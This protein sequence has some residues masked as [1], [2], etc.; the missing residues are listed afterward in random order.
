MCCPDGTTTRNPDT[1]TGAVIDGPAIPP[2]VDRATWRSARDELLARFARP[3][4]DVVDAGHGEHGEELTRAS[5]AKL[6]VRAAK[7]LGGDGLVVRLLDGDPALFSGFAEEALA[8]RGA[9]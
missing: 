8:L 9:R 7:A 2:V 3:D 6:L 5:R 4:V 1:T